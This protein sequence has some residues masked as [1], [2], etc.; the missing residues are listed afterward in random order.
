VETSRAGGFKK[1]RT[2]SLKA[3]VHPEHM[4]RALMTKKNTYILF[5]FENK[6]IYVDDCNHNH[7]KKS[8]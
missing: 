7:K 2:I 6:C 4:L 3:A 8:L 1:S 5:G